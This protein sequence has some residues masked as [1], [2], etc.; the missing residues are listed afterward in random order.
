MGTIIG[1]TGKISGKMGS[2]VFRVRNGQQ[3]VTQ[4]NPYVANPNTEAQ[5]AVRAKF[6]LITQLA[7]IMREGF[8]TLLPAKRSGKDGKPSKSNEF[9]RLNY[10]LIVMDEESSDVALAT[11][12]MEKLQLTNSFKQLGAIVFDDTGETPAAEVTV[13]DPSVKMVRFVVVGYETNAEGAS[14]AVVQEVVE[15][16]VSSGTARHELDLPAGNITVLAYG[17]IENIAGVARVDFDHIHTPADSDFISA[18][19]LEAYVRDG[20]MAET[21]TIGVNATIA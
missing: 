17:L 19:K 6:K 11:I 4:Y 16:P 14:Q 20:V 1:I 9:S 5:R 2:A 7:A 15:V 18:V 3:V 10:P 12:P 21:V 13:N 8:G